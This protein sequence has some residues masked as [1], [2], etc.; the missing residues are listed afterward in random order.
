ML[1]GRAASRFGQNLLPAE[2][3]Q[4]ENL[5]PFK[6]RTQQADGNGNNVLISILG[7]GILKNQNNWADGKLHS[8]QKNNP[9]RYPVTDTPT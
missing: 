8:F 7:R 1:K 3:I 5:S 4:P 9:I 2:S 6:P